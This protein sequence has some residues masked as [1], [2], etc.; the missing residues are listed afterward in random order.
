MIFSENRFT[1]RIKSG[2]GFFGIMR[3]SKTFGAQQRVGE[4]DQQPHGHE[5]GER[6]V[7]GHGA[8]SET[9]AG[10]G[11][12]ERQREQDEADSQCE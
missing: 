9:V 8:P 4:I 7:D 6:I 11:V 5:G 3:A 12:T 10:D 1:S 2:T